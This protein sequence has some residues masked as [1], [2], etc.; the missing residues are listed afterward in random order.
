[1]ARA[2]GRGRGGR[3][4]SSCGPLIPVLMA[5]VLGAGGV[6]PCCPRVWSDEPSSPDRAPPARPIKVPP[7]APRAPRPPRPDE[8]ATTGVFGVQGAGSRFVYL[9][10]RSESMATHGEAAL[11]AARTEVSESLGHLH[12]GHSFVILFYAEKVKRFPDAIGAKDLVP[13]TPDVIRR[14]KKAVADVEVGGR[15]GHA[16]ALEEAFVMN[17][18]VVFLITDSQKR[19]DLNAGELDKLLRIRGATKVMVVHLGAVAAQRCPNL[20]QLA[21]KT[22]GR[23]E[24]LTFD[25]TAWKRA[26]P[27]D[28]GRDIA[29]P[30][31]AR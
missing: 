22:G 28:G 10:D 30:A 19:D 26:S 5:A 16:K 25:G 24:A 7:M 2:C 15:A 27:A 6:A 17:P 3:R 18:D 11:D 8:A 12:K 14:A 9:F 4:S 23:Y 1:M 29:T 31:A 21:G 13:V 20:A